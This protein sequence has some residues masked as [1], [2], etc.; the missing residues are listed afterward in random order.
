MAS[1]SGTSWTRSGCT[2]GGLASD[3]GSLPLEHGPQLLLPEIQEAILIRS[4]LMQTD[5]IESRVDALL[6]RAQIG[7]GIRADGRVLRRLL[8]GDRLHRGF[9]VRGPADLLRE[10]TAERARGPELVHEL[11]RGRGVAPPADLHL[12]VSRFPRA[13][14]AVVRRDDLAIGV[15]GDEAIGDAASDSGHFRSTRR[16][17][18]RRRC[19]AERVET[20]VLDGEICPAVALLSSPEEEAQ[21]LDRLF[22]HLAARRQRRPAAADHVLVQVLAGADAEEE[23]TVEHD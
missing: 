6:D 4:D 18:D 20:R 16:D 14:G 9:E 15:R 2:E 10:L 22:E 7:L 12:D 19:L 8:D 17:I 11:A 21:D 5:V 1:R 3:R 13:A 23:A